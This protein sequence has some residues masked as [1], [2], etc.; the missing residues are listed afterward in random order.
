[1]AANQ[2]QQYDLNCSI[3]YASLVPPD[4]SFPAEHV[5]AT[6]P[7]KDIKKLVQTE[8][9][10]TGKKITRWIFFLFIRENKKCFLL[11]KN[12]SEV[13]FFSLVLPFPPFFLPQVQVF[14]EDKPIRTC[15]TENFPENLNEISAFRT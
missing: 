12:C 8:Y 14:Q 4:I 9:E 1:M 7:D 10:R 5:Q 2:H 13:T 11:R 15:L 3:L 6:T